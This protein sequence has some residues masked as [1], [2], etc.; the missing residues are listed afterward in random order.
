MAYEE[1]KQQVRLLSRDRN[2]SGNEFIGQIDLFA[3]QHNFNYIGED[4]FTKATGKNIEASVTIDKSNQINQRNH[5][6]SKKYVL[7]SIGNIEDNKRIVYKEF[8]VS[9]NDAPV[10]SAFP[11]LPDNTVIMVK[12]NM[13]FINGDIN[14]DIFIDSKSDKTIELGWG[15]NINSSDLNIYTNYEDVNK[16]NIFTGPSELM[17]NITKFP[18]KSD[19][20]FDWSYFDNY[21]PIIPSDTSDYNK[22]LNN[23]EDKK[24]DIL[25]MNS[26]KPIFTHHGVNKLTIDGNIN[27]VVDEIHSGWG[28]TTLDGD[29]KLRI[30]VNKAMKI[31]GGFNVG[32]N[33]ELE[34]IYLNKETPLSIS[35]GDD[36][37]WGTIIAPYS[38]VNVTGSAE[39]HGNIIAKELN[40]SGQGKVYGNV[41]SKKTKFSGSGHIFGSIVTENL[42]VDNADGSIKATK[43]NNGESNTNDPMDIDDLISTK[44]ATEK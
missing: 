20:N 32:N 18:M 35:G 16:K 41:Y 31:S 5:L 9:W 39:V 8:I 26:T 37:M 27:L 1:F 10:D 23:L 40:V 42:T 11:Q 34:I 38:V 19:N 24:E 14:G 28:I 44:P 25:D 3:E 33:I 36:L 29:G 30:I 12:N 15:T 22:T 4:Y 21:N 7:K 13:K 17:K 43:N 6:Y 2:Q